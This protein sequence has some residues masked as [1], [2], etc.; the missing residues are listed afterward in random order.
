MT[1]TIKEK[2]QELLNLIEELRKAQSSFEIAKISQKALK[3]TEELKE[4]KET[5]EKD[6]EMHFEK[7]WLGKILKEVQ[8][9]VRK[10]PKWM[11][12]ASDIRDLPPI[13]ELIFGDDLMEP[14]LT[15]EKLI[16]IRRYRKGAHDFIKGEMVEG[17]F[18]DGLTILL[19]ITED[20][21]IKAFA[22][23][24][25]EEVQEDGFKH[26]NNAMYS[27]AKYYPDL[28]WSDKAAIIRFKIFEMA[29]MPVVAR[30]EYAK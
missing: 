20:T 4:L 6:P 12:E 19:E 13:P 1:V 27:L 7:G 14:T 15:G 17:I 10:W 9:D 30:N 8:N 23:L 26:V 22:E 18:K 24:T 29:D 3:I 11:R 25:D 5:G 2:K 16:T 21:K 28:Q